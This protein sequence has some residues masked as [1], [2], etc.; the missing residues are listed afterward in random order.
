MEEP[1]KN[2]NFKRTKRPVMWSDEAQSTNLTP[3]RLIIVGS[4][5]IPQTYLLSEKAVKINIRLSVQEG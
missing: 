1:D 2:Y 5:I 3:E 4:S